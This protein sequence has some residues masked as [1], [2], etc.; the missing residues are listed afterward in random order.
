MQETLQRV[1]PSEP[2]WFRII[3]NKQICHHNSC[4]T[5]CVYSAGFL[6]MPQNHSEYG[7]TL[8]NTRHHSKTLSNRSYFHITPLM[9]CLLDFYRK[10][11]SLQEVLHYSTRWKLKVRLQ[12]Q[13]SHHEPHV[14]YKSTLP[15]AQMSC[16]FSY[17]LSM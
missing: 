17:V 1:G 6:F 2:R 7:F 5:A 12:H 15:K 13:S 4:Y 8:R 9:F 3:P 10:Y 11:Y 16:D 14:G